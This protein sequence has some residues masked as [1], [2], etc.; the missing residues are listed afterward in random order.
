MKNA[1]LILD[2]DYEISRIDPRIY[3]SFIEHLGRAVYGGIYEPSHPAADEQ[4]FRTD[5]LKLVKKLG[6]PVVRY[7]GGN[8][9]SGFNWEDSVGP[10]ENRPKRLDL[11]WFTTETNEFGLHEFCDWAKKAN[12]EVMYAVNLGTRGAENARDIVEY[13]NHPS[14]TKYSDMRIKNGRKDP[15][16]IKLWCLGNE[17]DGSWQIGHKTAYEYGRTAAESAKLMK[18]VDPSIELVVCGSSGYYMKTFGDWEYEVLSQCYENVDYISLHRYY[19]NRN[20]D[21]LSFLAK[22]TELE[23]FIKTV[24]SVCDSVKGK[25]HSK[26]QINLSFDEWNVWYHSSEQDK[27][28][29]KRDKWGRALPL[30]EDIYNFEDALLVGAM[31]ITFLRRSDRVKIACIAQLVNVIAPIMTRTGGGC[32]AQTIYYPLMHASL[33]GRGVSIKPVIK[34]EKYDCAEFNDVDYIDS[35]CVLNDDNSVTVFC[36]NRDMNDDCVLNI[37]MRSFGKMILSEH[38][39]LTNSDLYAVNT[40]LNPINVAPTYA[41]VENTDSGRTQVKLKPLSW[42]VL[43]FV[44]VANK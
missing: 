11:A 27:E 17:M 12:T 31:L 18:W 5:V 6:V 16:N 26:K 44:S 20:G 4:G 30:L 8:F 38:I 32:W 42:N 3:G 43:R 39:E 33:Y 9:V 36:I 13:A 15:L 25:L 21:T 23:D 40:E 28:I 34:C 2:R 19:D 7:P 41:E 37:D 22:S 1:D 35:A 10:V 14:G 24:V 29:Q